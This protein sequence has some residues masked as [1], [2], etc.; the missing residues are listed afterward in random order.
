MTRH[1]FL[2]MFTL[3]LLA[4]AFFVGCEKKSDDSSAVDKA[5]K[6]SKQETANPEGTAKPEEIKIEEDAAKGKDQSYAASHILIAYKGATRAAET[7]VRSKE[8]AEKLAKE[9]AAK[10]AK[11]P[12]QFE[13]LA[14][15]N[16]DCPSAPNGGD[17]GSWQ[18][19]MMVPEFEKAV[20]GME[21]GQITA[22]PVETPFG[23]HVIRRN[24][25]LKQEE[26]AAE[27]ILIAHK[28]S[29]RVPEGVTRT[30]EEAEKRAQEIVK[31][32]KAKPEAFLELAKEVSDDNFNS[33]PA[34]KTGT[35]RMPPEF[36]MALLE[37]EMNAVSEPIKTQ[38]G[39]HI[40]H[41]IPLPPKMSASHILVQYKGAQ[42]APL[43]I[44]RSKEEALKRAEEAL[45]KVK[46]DPAKFGENV[47]EYSDDPSA[48]MNQG[49]LGIWN[50]GSMVPEFE[51][52][53]GKLKVDEIGGPV[54]SP[55]GYHIILRQDPAKQSGK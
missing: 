30:V 1:R 17:L 50:K 14:K 7:V 31:K 34:W 37:L 27:H 53:L 8:E 21:I 46:A 52:A 13:T 35:N 41:R 11:D 16:S 28:D 22:A 48:V 45:A 9:L 12:A 4:L 44:T 38:Y 55:F 23:F 26:V 19:G 25:T 15:E 3:I 51:E 20:Q 5:E 43:S 42:S 6:A 47:K 33:L 54:E 36:D 18:S 49:N 2:L 29:S 40:F 10:L 24:K 32:A 39:F